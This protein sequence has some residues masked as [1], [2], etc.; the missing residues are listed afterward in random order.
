MVAGFLEAANLKLG[1][2]INFGSHPKVQIARF[3][4]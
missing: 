4:R 2:L 3:A 1:L